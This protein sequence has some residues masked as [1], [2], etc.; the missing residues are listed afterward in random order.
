MCWEMNSTAPVGIASPDVEPAGADQP[1]ESAQG[2][3]AE[4][5]S[6][7]TRPARVMAVANQ[8]GG[9][10][11]TTTAVN[12]GAALADLGLRVLIVDL[13]PQGNASTGL[14]IDPRSFD[15]S[16]Y[17]VLLH[18][19]AMEDCIEPTNIKNLFLAPSTLDLAGAEIE[20]VPVLSREHRLRKAIDAIGDDFAFVLID[21]PPSLGLITLNGFDGCYGGA[22]SD[23][24]RVL[25]AG[26]RLPTDPQCRARTFEPESDTGGHDH[27]PH[28][29]RRPDEA[30][31][32]GRL[33]RSGHISETSSA[34][35]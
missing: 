31:G 33:P 26:R 27:C 21:C 14:G 9:V 7:V 4:M 10:G 22:R 5:T 23:P 17:D 28:D 30:V 18:D 13:D 16:M 15:Y 1:A 2:A 11:K 25:R 24:V 29:V 3:V 35:T 6:P 12:L 32:F 34:R 19:V 8:K 20:L